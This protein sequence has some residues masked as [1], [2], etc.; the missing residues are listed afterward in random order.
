MI[1]F[2]HKRCVTVYYCEETAGQTKVF[3]PY[4]TYLLLELFIAVQKYLN[5]SRDPVPIYF[6]HI[7]VRFFQGTIS[8]W[9]RQLQSA[10]P[11]TLAA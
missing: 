5:L 1:C 7:T 3:P 10:T 11:A 4:R 6:K 2:G 8:S 9:T